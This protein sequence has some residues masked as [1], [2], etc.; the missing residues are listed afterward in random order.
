MLCDAS[1]VIKW[2]K[3]EHESEVAEA[4]AI[5]TAH[6]RGQIEARLLDLA[7]YEVGH[8]MTRRARWDGGRVAGILRDLAI[9][10][11]D[12]IRPQ[13][14]EIARAAWISAERGLSLFDSL[15]WA[16]AEAIDAILVSADSD[17]FRRGPADTP[18]QLCRRLGLAVD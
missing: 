17:L 18:T 2:F 16:A 10:L 3:P 15:Y 8:F 11:G 13:L 5:V 1:V 14:P 7:Y 4:R 9:A 12:P 6:G